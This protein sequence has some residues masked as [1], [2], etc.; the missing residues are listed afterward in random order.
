MKNVFIVPNPKKDLHYKVTRNLVSLL[1][2]SGASVSMNKRY[3]DSKIEFLRYVDDADENT[4]LVIVIGGDGSFIEASHYAISLNVPIIGVNLGKVGYLSEIEPDN[5]SVIKRIFSGEYKVNEKMLLSAAY[6]EN[7]EVKNIDRIAVNDVVVSHEEYLG[8]SDFVILSKEGG[9][10]Y[11]ADGVV[12]A[13]PQGSTAYSLSAGGPIVSHEAHSIIVTPI[14]PHSFFN[15][16]IVFAKGEE[17]KLKNKSAKALNLALD[18]RF[19]L[20]IPSG[21]ECVIK[22]SEKTLKVL[23]FKDNNMFSNLFNKMQILED[24]I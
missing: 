15:R 2:E 13:T 9:V 4:E 10:R 3:E 8:I 24:I 6:T 22:S 17:I 7:G 1:L 18:G 23:T 14:A 12:F 20:K 19:S 16:S 11:R 5:L 21:E